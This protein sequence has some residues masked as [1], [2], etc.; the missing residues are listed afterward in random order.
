MAAKRKVKPPKPR[1][2]LPW[3]ELTKAQQNQLYTRALSAYTTGAGPNPTTRAAY[4]RAK[5]AAQA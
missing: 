4:F 5:A 3:G 2:D 1:L